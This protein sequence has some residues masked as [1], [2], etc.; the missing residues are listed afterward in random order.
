MR[1]QSRARSLVALALVAGLLLPSPGVLSSQAPA[2]QAAPATAATASTPPKSAPAVAKAAPPA[3]AS[4]E[5][6]GGWPRAYTTPSGGQL[7]LY[8]PQIASWDEQKHMVAYGAVSYQPKG[9]QKP[10]LGTIK[11]ESD[12]GVSRGRA[13]RQ[14]RE[15][16]S[17]RGE[18]RHA[19]PRSDA[20]SRR[21]DYGRHSRARARDRARS[22]A[23]APRHERDHSE[24]CRRREGGSA[25]DL[26]QHEAGGTGERRRRSDLEPDQGQRPQVRRQHELGSVPA[27]PDEAFYLRTRSRGS[28]PRTSRDRGRPPARCPESFRSCRPTRTGRK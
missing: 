20:R 24:E 15:V 25:A 26:L 22:R 8:Q 23:R 4:P 12:T 5:A 13:A 3:A 19:R 1:G 21:D 11:I 27:R 14:V 28:R 9:A 18:V 17:H 2:G 6:D 16:A 7:L 10:E